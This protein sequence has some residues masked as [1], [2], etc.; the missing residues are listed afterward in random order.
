VFRFPLGVEGEVAGEPEPGVWR[1]RFRMGGLGWFEY[2]DR[3]GVTPLPP[4]IK[5]NGRPGTPKD[6][7][8]DRTR[9]QTVFARSVGSVAAPTAGLH[10]SEALC[11]EL[12]ERGVRFAEVTLHVGQATF[13]PVR[14]EDIRDHTVFPERY[15]VQ[16]PAAEAIQAARREGRRVVAVGT[17]VVR[18]LE[19]LWAERGRIEAATGWASL[20]V[21]PGHRFR[22]VDGLLTNFHLPGSSLL[23][24]VSAFAGPERTRHVYE[25]AV[26]LEYRFFSYGD[27][28]LIQ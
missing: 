21:I 25:E 2:L 10:F 1:V 22:V 18:C 11:R 4:Y 3:V 6:P 15:H 14:A 19:S 16:E 7:A 9:Y 13:L 23:M 26:R 5:R 28:M 8:E 20:Y 12:R 17:T 24:L 27:C